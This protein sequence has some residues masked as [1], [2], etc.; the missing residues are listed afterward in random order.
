MRDVARLAKRVQ[1]AIDRHLGDEVESGVQRALAHARLERALPQAIDATAHPALTLEWRERAEGHTQT[2]RL[3]GRVL[4]R[5]CFTNR[6]VDVYCRIDRGSPV[7]VRA[8]YDTSAA[9]WRLSLPG[10]RPNAGTF[11]DEQEKVLEMLQDAVAG[12]SECVPAN[13]L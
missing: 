9:L 10:R 2:V 5:W 8:S 13:S 11:T 6:H 3:A 1:I 12:L 7:H 4:L